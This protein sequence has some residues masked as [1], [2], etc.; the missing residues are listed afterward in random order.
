MGDAELVLH[1]VARVN[2]VSLS[3]SYRLCRAAQEYDADGTDGREELGVAHLMRPSLRFTSLALF[4]CWFAVTFIYYGLGFAAGQMPGD[5]YPNS[6]MLAMAE[7]PAYAIIYFTLED[8]RV[9]RRW[10]QIGAF[11]SAGSALI[12]IA[13]VSSAGGS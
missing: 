2:G 1:V 4:F 12:A 5:V 7:M 9:A 3:D 10:T 8:P 13:V 11:L 6:A